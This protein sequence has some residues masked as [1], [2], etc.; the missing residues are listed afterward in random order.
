M[1]PLD[2][3]PQDRRIKWTRKWKMKMEAALYIYIY[4]YIYR[5]IQGF[6]VL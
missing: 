4:I 6:Y 1:V 2:E 5:F 3:R